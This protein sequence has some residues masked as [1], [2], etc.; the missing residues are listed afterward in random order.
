MQQMRALL[1]VISEL[2]NLDADFSGATRGIRGNSDGVAPSK[3]FPLGMARGSRLGERETW[4]C[5]MLEGRSDF[6]LRS[7][8]SANTDSVVCV[9]RFCL[10]VL[11]LRCRAA[12]FRAMRNLSGILTPSRRLCH[13]HA[14]CRTHHH[15]LSLQH[16]A[17]ALDLARAGTAAFGELSFPSQSGVL[18]LVHS[19]WVYSQLLRGGKYHILFRMS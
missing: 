10:R 3:R 2:S 4:R 15:R 7:S 18:K 8:L 11:P 9:L 6:P 12:V 19:R 17:A 13:L 5:W 1:R 14:G 16:L